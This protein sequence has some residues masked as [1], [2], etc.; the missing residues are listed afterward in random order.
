MSLRIDLELA[1][2]NLRDTCR[3]LNE[4]ILALENMVEDHF[5]IASRKLPVEAFRNIE[6]DIHKIMKDPGS[7]EGQ[8]EEVLKPPA[9][10]QN[11]KGLPK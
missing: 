6:R 4:D 2:E 9:F 8:K 11:Q 10:L 1:L 3:K 7:A 5:N